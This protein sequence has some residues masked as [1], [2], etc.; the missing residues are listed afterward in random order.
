MTTEALE[1]QPPFIEIEPVD[2]RS[3]RVVDIPPADESPSLPIAKR[4]DIARLVEPSLVTACEVLYDKNIITRGFSVSR[5]NIGPDGKGYASIRISCE[6]LSKEN[7]LIGKKLGTI[8]QY[9]G[10]F[11]LELT[12]P[13]TIYTTLAEVEKMSVEKANS[14]K[15]QTPRFDT[16]TLNDRGLPAKD[17][18]AIHDL[19]YD[20]IERKFYRSLEQWQLTHPNEKPNHHRVRYK[21]QWSRNRTGGIQ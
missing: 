13:I 7:L 17:I 2:S 9:D 21:G 8:I 6:R 3:L 15:E 12:F 5:N 11:Q 10:E 4:A 16:W 1:Y 14:F 19:L 18:V 20:E